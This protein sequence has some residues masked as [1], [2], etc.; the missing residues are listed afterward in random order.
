MKVALA[1]V[2]PKIADKQANIKTMEQYIN[3]TKADLYIFPELMLTGYRCKDEL[4]NL[5]EP[6][7]GPAIKQLKKISENKNASIVFGM[8]TTH[9]ITGLIH[10]SAV[11][12]QPNGKVGAYNKWFLPTFGPFEEK[13]F[14]NEGE[15]LPVFKT[16]HGTIGLLVCYDLFFPELAKSLTLQGAELIIY[17]SATP[18]VNRKYFETLIPARAVE[19]TTY[20]IYVNIVGTQD[21]LVF[22]GGAQAYNPLG[23]QIKK[24]PYYKQ[25]LITIDID[26]TKIQQARAARPVIRDVRPEIFHDLYHIAR[27]NKK[28]KKHI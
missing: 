3:K 25:S 6:L 22:W 1:T 11:L 27:Y 5:A 18:S 21:D 14:F 10:N 8:P 26:F 19:N 17:L 2:R 15:N 16:K 7:N 9:K 20:V 28:Q 24:A 4:R 12:I 13:L 23:K